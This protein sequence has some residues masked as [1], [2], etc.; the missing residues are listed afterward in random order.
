[1]RKVLEVFDPP[2]ISYYHHA[3][4]LSMVD[5]KEQ[6]EG[7]FLSNFIQLKCFHDLPTNR[8]S[9]LDFF[10][11]TYFSQYDDF[12]E[13]VVRIYPG[14]VIRFIIDAINRNEYVEAILNDYYI[15]H[16]ERY[17]VS[18]YDHNIL[19]YGYD[20]S[21]NIFYTRFIGKKH[22]TDYEITFDELET[23]FLQQKGVP[24]QA[25][26]FN[27]FNYSNGKPQFDM[28]R[29]IRYLEDYLAS[30]YRYKQTQFALGLEVYE[31]IA[32]YLVELRE[33]RTYYDIRPLHLLWEHKAIMLRR[34]IYLKNI[35]ALNE[36][37][38]CIEDFEKLA[39]I[40]LSARNLLLKYSITNKPNLLD[41][42]ITIV[43]DIKSQERELLQ[44]VVA[45]L[46][47]KFSL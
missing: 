40:A 9:Q 25:Y 32:K 30:S 24:I 1:M 22:Y 28:K 35:E 44:K 34:I 45:E 23:A 7:W 5:T 47:S 6:Y 3:H 10:H 17:L 11:E 12:L 27:L 4:Y 19:V 42:A 38:A 31:Y 13:D 46:R 37:T 20:T 29:I 36:E 33:K 39:K 18:N 14:G 8:L 26:Y 2:I 21:Q 41:E 15:P 43:M 16:S